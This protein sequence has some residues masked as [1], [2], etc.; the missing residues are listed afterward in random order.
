HPENKWY[1][2]WRQM[3]RQKVGVLITSEAHMN[4]ER[5]AGID[6]LFGRAIRLEYSKHPQTANSMGVAFVLNKNMIKTGKVTTRE[7]VPGRAMLIEVLNV[8][9]TP[10]SI[11]GVYAPNQPGENATFWGTIKEYFESNPDVRKPDIMGGDSNMVEDP[12]DRLP[13][14]T[15]HNGQVQTL[16]DLKTYLG[17]VDGWRETYPSAC[18]YTYTQSEAQGGAQS[19][20]DRLYVKRSIF[21][22]TF[23]WEI[24][25]AEIETD[26]KMVSLMLTTEDAPTIGHGR[27]VWPAYLMKDKTLTEYITKRG[28]EMQAELDAMQERHE[29]NEVYNPQTLWMKFKNDIHDK[30]RERS[31]ILVPRMDQEIAALEVKQAVINADETLSDEEKGMS[32]VVLQEKLDLL[33]RKRHWDTRLATKAR[34]KVD[35]EMIG[36]WW[37]KVNKEHKPRD[38]IQRLRKPGGREDLPLYEKNSKKMATI[39]RNYHNKIQSDR[40]RTPPQVREE[41]IETVLNR[42]KT[43]TTPEQKELLKAR[44]TI[45]DVIEALKKSA[46]YKAPGLNGITYEVWK[47]LDGRYHT[48]RSLEKPAFNVLGAMLK[49]FN[50]IEIH[51]M[52]EK[53]GFSESWMCPLYKKNDKADIANYRPISLLNTDYKIFTKALTIKL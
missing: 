41:K 51:G 24:Q 8:D 52:V 2:I 29:R 45:E 30:A 39:A 10:L 7:I 49:V 13:A 36:R 25:T 3:C 16:D 14:R 27:W 4:D 31:K 17:L 38:V 23:E 19:R 26:H 9:D 12:V 44:L 6:G 37:S 28:L 35:G 11:L 20:I 53:T 43:R 34:D 5:K 33:Y 32:G 22:D 47:T 18:A 40:A 1:E 21:N 48:A 42:T 46:N 15:D 50:D